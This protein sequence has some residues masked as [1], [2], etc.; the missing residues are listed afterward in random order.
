MGERAM[1][2]VVVV[3]ELRWSR[4]WAATRI[5]AAMAVVAKEV[6]VWCGWF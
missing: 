1:T 6:M 2:V 3:V 5:A 4:R